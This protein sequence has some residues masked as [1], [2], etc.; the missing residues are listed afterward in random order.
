M[1]SPMVKYKKLSPKNLTP[2]N[3]ARKGHPQKVI[4]PKMLCP[5]NQVKK[6]SSPKRPISKKF[7]LEI[8]KSIPIGLVQRRA[9]IFTHGPFRAFLC[10]SGVRFKSSMTIQS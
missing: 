1:A 7:K 10:V 2:K 5:N 6:K 3:Q 4:M 8:I 9:T